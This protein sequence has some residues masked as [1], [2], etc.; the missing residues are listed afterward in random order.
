MTVLLS[1]DVFNVYQRIDTGSSGVVII[2]NNLLHLPDKVS[3]IVFTDLP[4]DGIF[5]LNGIQV[6]ADQTEVSAS[7]IDS[8]SLTWNTGVPN[9]TLTLDIAYYGFDANDDIVS[10][11]SVY[12][13]PDIVRDISINVVNGGNFKTNEAGY[14]VPP[15]A[16]DFD[17]ADYVIN[18]YSYDGG[19]FN[20]GERVGVAPPPA[21]DF[22]YYDNGQLDPESQS[23]VTLLDENLN[24]ILT[25]NLPNSQYTDTTV[26]PIDLLFNVDYT[27]QMEIKYVTKFFEGFDYGS[28][29]PNTGYDIDYGTVTSE[30][31]E[32]YDFNSIADYSEPTPG[33]IA[34]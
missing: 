26:I 27:I 14:G 21:S 17:T 16:G 28:I 29:T 7:Q 24:P 20:T 2:D 23:I 30:N 13:P 31:P 15:D 11:L 18:G 34:S 32:G 12:Y 10:L 33:N 5:L 19:D 4:T 6:L 25:S 22:N 9:S 8:L 3:Y 1:P